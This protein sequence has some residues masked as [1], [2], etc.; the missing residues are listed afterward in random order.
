MSYYKPSG[1]FAFKNTPITVAYHV[2]APIYDKTVVPL[3]LDYTPQA[4]S[5]DADSMY[6][7]DASCTVGALLA[8]VLKKTIEIR[9]LLV[10]L[11]YFKSVK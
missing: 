9:K 6:G 3:F 10:V 11:F 7:R 2:D 4:Y 1:F 5:I 8:I